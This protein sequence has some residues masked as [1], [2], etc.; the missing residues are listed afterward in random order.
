MRMNSR[1]IFPVEP[2]VTTIQR[3]GF[4]VMIDETEYFVDFEDYP[5][6]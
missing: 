4:W 5:D 2:D 1:T 3:S 6:F